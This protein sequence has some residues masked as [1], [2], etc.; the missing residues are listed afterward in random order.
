VSDSLSYAEQLARTR[1]LVHAHLPGDLATWIVQQLEA[2]A[3]A[4]YLRLR[5]D[6]WLRQAG[7][8]IGGTANNRAVRILAIASVIDRCW[9]LYRLREPEPGTAFGAVH[10]AR[11]IL[12]IP[13]RR[14][15]LKLL[16]KG[17]HSAS[18]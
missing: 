5:R 14:Q 16:A 12:A 13:R 17:M 9:P 18:L 4:D 10:S 8:I 15:L 6:R 1:A 3:S 11:Q 2:N 7:E